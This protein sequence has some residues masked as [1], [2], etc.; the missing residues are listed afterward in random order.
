MNQEYEAELHVAEQVKAMTKKAEL[1]SGSV[2]TTAV[3]VVVQEETLEQLQETQSEVVVL[4]KSS[5]W[6]SDLV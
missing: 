4:Y 2:D 5:A 6:S 3:A 1:E